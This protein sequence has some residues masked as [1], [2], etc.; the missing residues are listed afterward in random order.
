VV[1]T[2]LA[3]VPKGPHD[4]ALAPVAVMIDRNLGLLRD[5]SPGQIEVSLEFAL[6]RPERSGSRSERASR[7]LEAALANVEMHGWHG[8][9]TVDNSRLRLSGG[10]V[11]LDLGLSASIVRFIEAGPAAR[12]S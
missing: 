11:T 9:I 6:N 12:R 4:L 7:V 5:C 8:E 1:S 2:H 3:V 10:S